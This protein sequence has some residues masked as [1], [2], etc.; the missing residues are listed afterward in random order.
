MMLACLQGWS[1]EAPAEPAAVKSAAWHRL[2]FENCGLC[3]P[4]NASLWDC[5]V[6]RPRLCSYTRSAH[7]FEVVE[8]CLATTDG[9]SSG[10]GAQIT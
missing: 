5:H 10:L 1:S 2:V 7:A 9:T 4:C 3:L 8:P 6:A